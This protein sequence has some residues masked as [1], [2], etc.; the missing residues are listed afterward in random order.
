MARYSTI[1]VPEKIKQALEKN[2]G[3]KEW[4]EY[5]MELYNKADMEKRRRA[6]E[7]IGE[8]LSEEDYKHMKESSERFKEEFRLR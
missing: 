6:L 3:E 4:G 1:S 2:K 5:L 8:I 7:K